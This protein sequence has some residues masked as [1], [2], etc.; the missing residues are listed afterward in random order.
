MAPKTTG[1]AL[2]LS[3]KLDINFFASLTVFA[4][5]PPYRS[6]ARAR[7]PW[8]ASRSQKLLKKSFNPHQACKTSTP[9]R[10]FS[11]NAMYP[12]ALPVS[13]LNSTFRP[14]CFKVGKPR[15]SSRRDFLFFVEHQELGENFDG[16]NFQSSVKETPN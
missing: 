1:G 4:T 10:G 11:G 6:G 13:L 3:S 14:V 5:G 16:R 7:K 2:E 9:P 12:V 15:G 8:E